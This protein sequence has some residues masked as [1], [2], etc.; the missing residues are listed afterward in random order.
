MFLLVNCNRVLI[1]GCGMSMYVFSIMGNGMFGFFYFFFV[2][3]VWS[4]LRVLWFNLFS[5]VW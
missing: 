3:V 2:S 1:S 5:V 4:L